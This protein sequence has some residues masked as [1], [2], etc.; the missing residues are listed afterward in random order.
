MTTTISRT[1]QSVANGLGRSDHGGFRGGVGVLDF[2]ESVTS[3]ARTD[4][5]LST[6][7]SMYCGSDDV[8]AGAPR[9]NR[10]GRSRRALKT[11]AA[12]VTKLFR[13]LPLS[14]LKIVVGKSRLPCVPY[15]I[16]VHYDDAEGTP[17]R[18]ALP[19]KRRLSRS[20]L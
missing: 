12:R 5:A 18:F 4:P 16:N 3:S 14:K 11:I 20:A 19:G 8:A 10:A 13:N 9:E 17:A 15:D 6:G 1:K 7:G 2:G